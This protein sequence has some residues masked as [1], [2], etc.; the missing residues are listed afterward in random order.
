MKEFIQ[1]SDKCINFINPKGQSA[2]VILC[3]V[4]FA[5]FLVII[6]SQ[7]TYAAINPAFVMIDVEQIF[8]KISSSA[9]VDEEFT[10][11][12]TSLN[13]GNPMPANSVGDSYRFKIV[14]TTTTTIGPIEFAQA[15]TYLYEV[16]NIAPTGRGQQYTYDNEVYTIRILVV[17]SGSDFVATISVSNDAYEKSAKIDFTNKY[18]ALPSDPDVMVDP[19]VKKTV[20]GKPSKAGI[21]S[22]TLTAALPSNPMPAGSENGRKI[23]SITGPG[24]VEFGTWIYTA[25]GSYFYTIAEVNNNEAGYQYDR[26]VYTIMDVVKDEGGVLKV[27][28]TIENANG[29]QVESLT[30]VNEYNNKIINYLTGPKTGD[31]SS[32]A[33]YV[34]LIIAAGIIMI[35]CMISLRQRGL[36][37]FQQR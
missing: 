22:F 27:Y 2:K 23:M 36:R 14:G 24:E 30:F 3:A 29:K 4:L 16:K 28:R 1:N 35:I 31:D 26:M 25:E 8:E 10:Y 13:T 32:I 34:R 20:T 15:G 37:T 33:L 9:D 21:F 19:P 17:Q 5:C 6:P 18:Q 7:V 12:F 11:E